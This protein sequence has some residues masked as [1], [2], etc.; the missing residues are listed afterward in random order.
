M[1]QWGEIIHF[2]KKGEGNCGKIALDEERGRKKGTERE[3]E[4]ERERE[5]ERETGK[6]KICEI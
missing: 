5:K 6:G 1:N 2:W 3:R 4:R